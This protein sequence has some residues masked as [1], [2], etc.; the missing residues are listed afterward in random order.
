MIIWI[1]SYPKSGN[2][3][4]RSLISAYL[5]GKDG[6]FDFNLLKKIH[7]FPSQKYF[8][9]FLKDFT[10]MKKVSDHWIAAQER[11]NLINDGT[12][13]LK[14]HNA[15]CTFASNPFT[16]KINTKAAIYI[17]RDP[18][19]LLTSFSHHYSMNIQDTYNYIINKKAWI[20]AGVDDDEGIPSILGSWSEHYKSWKNLKFASLLIIRYEDLIFDTKN[21]FIK[22]IN[23][24]SKFIEV[25]FDENKINNAINTCGFDLL[26]KKE[27]EE[28]FFESV[29]S[30]KDKKTLNFFYLGKKN[31]WKNLLDPNIEK[32]TREVFAEEMKELKYI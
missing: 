7:Q 22:I 4:V 15:L 27:K 25:K 19:N 24:L 17:V 20:T 5:Y 26:Q 16:N 6:F 13:I 14:T 12:T 1:A 2:T 31:N 21:S 10:D 23:F 29:P 28:G 3:W 11:I 8:E 30:K 9:F 32:K 18:R